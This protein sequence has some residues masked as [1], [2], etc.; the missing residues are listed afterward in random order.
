MAGLARKLAL[1]TSREVLRR[2]ESARLGMAGQ[3]REV[4]G[5]GG[6]T[7]YGA[8]LNHLMGKQTRGR[9]GEIILS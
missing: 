7:P 2:A 8:T 3:S 5:L 4:S 9:D 1:L 6:A